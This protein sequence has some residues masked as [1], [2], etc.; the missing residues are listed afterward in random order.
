LMIFSTH[1]QVMMT[2]FLL[3]NA[4]MDNGSKSI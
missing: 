4:F 3:I 1:Q 2:V